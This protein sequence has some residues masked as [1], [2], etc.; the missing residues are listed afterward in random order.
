MRLWGG[1]HGAR[2]CELWALASELGIIDEADTK[3]QKLDLGGELE[4]S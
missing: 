1:S 3:L 4:G 2:L